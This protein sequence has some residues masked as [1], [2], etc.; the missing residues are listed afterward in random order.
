[1]SCQAPAAFVSCD[2]PIGAEARASV[3]G[4]RM[5]YYRLSADAQIWLMTLYDK[6]EMADLSAAE[7]RALRAALEAELARRAARRRQRRK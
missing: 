4:L 3:V 2:G 7:K 5:I 6:D 1:M